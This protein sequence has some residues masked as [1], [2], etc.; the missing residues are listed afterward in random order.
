MEVDYIGA[1]S[2][3]SLIEIT[4]LS[5]FIISRIGQHKNMV[6]IFEHITTGSNDK[7]VNS[8]NRWAQLT[9]NNLPYEMTLFNSLEDSEMQGEEVRNKK[10]GKVLRFTFCLNKKADYEQRNTPAQNPVQDVNLAIENALMKFQNKQNDNAILNKLTEMEARLNEMETDESFEDETELSGLNNPNLTSILGLLAG[11]LK[12]NAKPTGTA[13][14]G[15]LPVQVE[16]INKAV[17]ILSRHDPE[18]DTDLLKLSNLAETKPATFEMLL[19]T[20]RNM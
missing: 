9:D 6:P 20:L 11:A 18:I 13:I 4:G 3:A 1:G 2:V 5:K 14:N 10:Q 15:L 7:A 19:K 8:F 17:K 16:N 12:G